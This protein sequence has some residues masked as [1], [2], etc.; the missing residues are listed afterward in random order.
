M[1][2]PRRITIAS[3]EG[4]NAIAVFRPFTLV[5]RSRR[6]LLALALVLA[7]LAAASLRI[8]TAGGAPSIE[9]VVVILQENHSFD[10]V[11]GQLCIQDHRENC[12]AAS[13]GE[14]EK[15]ETIPLSKASDVVPGVGHDQKSQLA[16]MH[17]GKMDGWENVS[18]C[19]QNQ[20]YTAYEPSQIPSLAALAREGA[21][22]DAFFSRDIVPSWGAHLD[23]FA[24]TLDGFVG[25]NPTKAKHTPGPGWGCDSFLDAAWINPVTHKTLKEPSCV[26]DREGR[27]PYRKSPVKYVP[28]I[29]D[30]LEEAGRTW[31]IYG[32]VV[33]KGKAQGGYIWST[34]PTFAECL[35][36]PQ[37][38]NMH[39]AAQ[40]MSDAKAGKLPSFSIV[41]PSTDAEGA[42]SQHNG[43]SMLVGDN[44]IG[45][46]V[47]AVKAGAD[48]ATTTIFIYYDDCGCFYDH[49]NPPAG[50]G[51]RSP[52]VIVSPLAKPG[53]TDNETATNSSIMAYMETVLH[54][55]P[56]SEEDRTAYNFHNS[57][58]SVATPSKFVFHPPT[59]PPSSRGLNPPDEAT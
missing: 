36:G 3:R 25:D 22:S 49:V 27:G 7:G 59:V 13:S 51:I 48:A 11:L 33:S 29:A 14:N 34:C 26:P 35:L 24:Q 6:A 53:F 32:A 45:K 46:A 37:K 28:T 42:T 10:N 57:F 17:K 23:F 21:I 9:H 58:S 30:R 1:T 50:L 44:Y 2:A 12:H 8:T 20:C 16:A 38:E 54:V 52:L 18:G 19:Q 39:E 4:R 5:R 43:T 56:V 41:T 31:G 40:F 15:G 47:A 55:N